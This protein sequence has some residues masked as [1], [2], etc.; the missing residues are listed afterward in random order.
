MDTLAPNPVAATRRIRIGRPVEPGGGTE[1]VILAAGRGSRLAAFTADRPKCLVEVGGAPLIEHQLQM[2]GM[3]GIRRVSVV[4]GYRA[5]DVARAVRGRAR[6]VRNDAWNDTN[7]LYSLSLCRGHVAGPLLVMNC[8]VLIHPLA[9]QRLLDV[10][11]SAFLYDSTSGDAEE[12]MKVELSAQGCLAAMSKALPA[13]RTHGEN[14]GVLRFE[15]A[16]A[17]ALF[18]AAEA[19]VAAGHRNAWMASAVE[20]VAR[21]LPLRGV[22]IAD[23]PWIEIDFPDDLERA[24]AQVWRQ[25]ARA[26]APPVRLAA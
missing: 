14:V 22:D 13:E 2:L 18:R 25:V 24:C 1:A 20:R 7:S 10:P 15:E 4:A 21:A 26:L 12:H 3:A 17:A 9:L 23:L 11:G 6:V 5:E 19:L 8:D 16:G